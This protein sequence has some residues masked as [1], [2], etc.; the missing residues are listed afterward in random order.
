MKTLCHPMA[1]ELF[2]HDHDP[3][4]EYT[5][6]SA[7]L[8]ESALNQPRQ[9]FD[10]KDLYP[11][12]PKKAAVLYYGLNKNHPFRNGNKRISVTALFTFL[13]INGY[14]LV[15]SEK[16]FVEMTLKVAQSDSAKHGQ[17]LS[18]IEDWVESNIQI[19]QS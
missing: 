12:L 5:E 17:I 7:A 15:V 2:D 18:E 3:I 9:A 19:R 8:L 10:G 4:G 14:T 11:T 1:V 16:S 13:Y 6:E